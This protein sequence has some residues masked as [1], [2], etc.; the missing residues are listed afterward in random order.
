MAIRLFYIVPYYMLKIW[1]YGK[2]SKYTEEER[3]AVLSSITRKVNKAGRVNIKAYGLENIPEE[4]GFVIFPNHQGLFDVLTFLDSCPKPFAIVMK[5]EVSNIILIKQ[6]RIILRGLA[7][8]RGDV[9]QS[10]KVI[11]Q[12][13]E[14]VKA[15]RNYLIFAE[16][17]RTRNKNEL[18]EFKAGS[19]KSAIN[20]K[21]PIVPVAIIDSY[22]PFDISSIKP[23]TVQI[24][25]LKSIPYE[26]YQG[27]K[28]REVAE[29]VKERIHAVIKEYENPVT[30]SEGQN[31]V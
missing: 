7:I 3:Y 26:E 29:M 4:N 13:T 8:D 9:R 10:M 6:V 22:K 11:M 30:G 27:M 16:G 23:V 14:E 25:Y 12:M 2:S 1:W 5:K 31:S 18:L 15:G 20:A 17:T 19:F 28:T 24:H 21:C